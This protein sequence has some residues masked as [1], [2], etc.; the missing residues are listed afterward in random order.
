MFPVPP[1]CDPKAG[2]C[3]I[4]HGAAEQRPLL[5]GLSGHLQTKG[6]I[7]KGDGYFWNYHDK[8]GN[9]KFTAGLDKKEQ[10]GG[11]EKKSFLGFFAKKL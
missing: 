1:L 2:E 6:M 4:R 5:E 8:R 10:V 7:R 9:E 3:C 11:K